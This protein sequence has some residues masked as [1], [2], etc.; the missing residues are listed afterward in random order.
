MKKTALIICALILSVSVIFAGGCYNQSKANLTEY[1]IKCTLEDNSLSATE[2]VCFINHTKSALT[3]L[4][5]NLF[6]NAF[7]KDASFSPISAQRTSLK[8]LLHIK[9]RNLF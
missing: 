7:R 8:V 5:F 3:E 9:Q 4:K 1:H 2:N 6:A